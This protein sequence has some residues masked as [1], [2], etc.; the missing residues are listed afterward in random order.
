MTGYRTI[1]A[2]DEWAPHLTAWITSLRL[3]DLS[4]GT[5]ELRDYQMRR[6]STALGKPPIEVTLD[7][8]TTYLGSALIDNRWNAATA[9]SH[10]NAIRS[11]YQWAAKT[12]R[13]AEDPSA[14]LPAIAAPP[15][16]PKP[17]PEDDFR[18]ALAKADPTVRMMV[19][20]SGELGLRRAEVA[21][22]HIDHILDQDGLKVLRVLGKGRKI[23]HLPLPDRLA[24]DLIDHITIRGKD[25]WAF[26]STMGGHLTPHWVGTKVSAVLPPGYTMHKLRHRAAT[27]A[28]RASGDLLLVS[29]MLG[30]STVATT[31]IYVQPDYS[32]L[33]QIVSGLGVEAS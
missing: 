10:R 30:H 23:R 20:L 26:P 9:R 27:Q 31:Q 21:G 13:I 6:I 16:N 28:H 8:L 12:K 25:G 3:R 17:V 4:P 1:D 14:D 15:R 22:V 19:R 11:F 29:E 33:R 18:A 32:R 5:I 2:P 24:A 7:D